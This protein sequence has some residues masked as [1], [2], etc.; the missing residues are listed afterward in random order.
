[1]S[2]ALLAFVF[3]SNDGGDGSG[4]NCSG[5][6]KKDLDDKALPAQVTVDPADEYLVTQIQSGSREAFDTLVKRYH[7]KLVATACASLD[8]QAEA[9]DIV[10]DILITI[11]INHQSW[12]PVRGAAVYLFGSL[13]NRIRNVWRDKKR[14]ARSLELVR[15]EMQNT[16][17]DGSALAEEVAVV[18]EE[19]GNL[20]E[21]WRTALVL[22]YM[23]DLTFAQVG[24]SMNI[25]ENAAKKL[26]QRAMVALNEVLSRKKIKEV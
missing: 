5:R 6:G 16:V 4:R 21:R 17:S 2:S 3:R 26:V 25:S 20:P 9:E 24:T 18:W 13:S 1:M 10:Q 8:S 12:A 7:L 23:N 19:V 14:T 22:K 15:A 11:W